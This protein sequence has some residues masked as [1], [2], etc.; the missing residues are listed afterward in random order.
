MNIL[1]AVLLALAAPFL[2]SPADK[3][4]DQRPVGLRSIDFDAAK[5][6]ARIERR[7][8]LMLF[9]DGETECQRIAEDMLEEIK[10][11]TW[12]D[13]KVVAIQVDKHAQPDLAARYRIRVTPTYLFSDAKG[14]ELDR[15]VGL[16]DSKTL[17]QEGEEILKGGDAFERLQ[18]KRK[19][20]ESDP[21]MRLRYAD[22]L[23]DRGELD[24]ALAEYLAV[25]A[26]GG[27]MSAAAFEELT[28]MARIYPKAA[29]AIAGIA[30]TLEPRIRSGLATDEEFASWFD[31]S[32]RMKSELR[33]L[34]LYDAMA[35]LDPLAAGEEP[36]GDDPSGEEP[37]GG[38]PSGANP[39]GDAPSA[40]PPP[41][42]A[43]N[44]A[45]IAE[46]R[47]RIAP[48]L[49][50]LFYTDQRY[51][52]YAALVRDALADLEV[53]KEKHA[54]IAIAGDASATKT[55]LNLL[56]EDT[57]RDYEALIAV[58]RLGEGTLLADALITYD[59]TVAT[60]DSLVESAVRANLPAEA[61]LLA[62]RGRSD[63]RIDPK[64]RSRIAPSIPG[65][66]K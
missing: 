32:R 14:T 38:E 4:A 60:Y 27:P 44:A 2:V 5:S 35:P 47:Q 16:R 11:R 62:L 61:R 52:D 8:I 7:P 56:R 50:D 20:R 24:G 66:A 51:A 23:C 28:R 49:R 26:Q 19:G 22:F 34:A 54:E 53:R 39:S 36:S 18:K 1:S 6:A 48:A 12:L 30:S 45:R 55:S 10:L 43:R 59:P 37:S 9:C 58:K 29:D 17:R 13:D 15:L 65:G 57:A 33:M 64:S 63:V 31:L 46:L 3:L 21:E 42:A 41:E 40:A 25:H